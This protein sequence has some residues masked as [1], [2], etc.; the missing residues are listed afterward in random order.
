M[1]LSSTTKFLRRTSFNQSLTSSGAGSATFAA[2]HSRSSLVSSSS[3]CLETEWLLRSFS[4]VV[5]RATINPSRGAG[6]TYDNFPCTVES[7][8]RSLTGWSLPHPC[9]GSTC[10]AAAVGSQRL[11]TSLFVEWPSKYNTPSFL[12]YQQPRG[13]ARRVYKRHIRS[14]YQSCGDFCQLRLPEVSLA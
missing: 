6:G 14:T 2:S 9:R 8:K 7:C 1:A 12:T 11:L 4:A 3:Y 13:H 5:R 10:S